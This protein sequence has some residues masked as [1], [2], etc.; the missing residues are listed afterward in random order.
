MLRAAGVVGGRLWLAAVLV[1]LG[2]ARVAY[3][4]PPAQSSE[5]VV[6]ITIDTLRPDHLG[7][8]GNKLV[9]T[10]SL[11][12]LAR[13]GTRFAQAVTSI[14][15][16]LPSHASIL[17]GTYPP[18]HGVRDMGGFV[19]KPWLATLATVLAR[20][21]FHTAAS[22]GSFALDH[23]FG[24]SRGFETYDDVMPPLEFNAA[25]IREPER[26]ASTVADHALTWLQSHPAGRFFL[27]VHF[28]D[29]HTPYDPPP[30]FRSRYA[31]RL[32]DGEIAYTDTQVGRLIQALRLSGLEKQ[33]L[34]V[35]L[36]DHGE[37]LGEH[38]ESTHGVFLYDSTVRIPLILAG[39][40]TP[41]GKVAATQVRSID[42]MPTILSLLR[43][44]IPAEVQGI[45]LQGLLNGRPS[46][47]ESRFAYLESIYPRTHF[48]WSELRAVRSA[49]WKYIESP[50]EELYDLHTD[51]QEARNSLQRSPA[52]LERYRK[53]LTGILG[54]SG[55]DE[56]VQIG[57]L[58]VETRQE[59]ASLGYVSARS[60]NSLRLDRS[61]PDPKTRIG[62][63]RGFESSIN[64]ES[65]HD[66]HS[67]AAK[68]ESLLASDPANPLFY[69]RLGT[70][71][72]L[73]GDSRQ[74]MNTYERALSHQA[75]TDELL[76]RLGNLRMDQGDFAQA[77]EAFERSLSLDPGY[78]ESLNNLGVCYYQMGR[79]Q[80]SEGAFR[81]LLSSGGKQASAY[82][83]LGLIRVKQGRR[84]EAAEDF[85]KALQADSR[86][87][88]AWLNLGVYYDEEGNRREAIRCFEEFI[89]G[90]PPAQY[91]DSIEGAREAAA[92]L[93][94]N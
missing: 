39:P 36:G 13:R 59:L 18:V 53:L 44:P 55:N 17:T 66:Y 88:E 41:A 12:A 38:G 57:S 91:K 23:R 94:A 11:D 34:L 3:G 50:H 42:V 48:G 86:F 4:R 72:E 63:L 49:D 61:R 40:R 31:G 87:W 51:P 6:L 5:N 89:R 22:V 85:R 15:L 20:S 27:W 35:V 26:R 33:T 43:I 67:A 32:Y 92:R 82:N 37:S 56:T 8:Y 2:C 71:Y 29:P 45:S 69:L 70:C 75:A 77:A 93:R 64:L 52:T 25:V 30:P 28:F 24:L 47:P 68:L 1:Y 9:D 76:Y 84:A 78:S 7:C 60:E 21:G 14:P 62:L 54:R 16:T 74:A 79:L 19:L 81:R 90:A 10:P 80:D 65:R 73:A 46:L 83:G 58:S